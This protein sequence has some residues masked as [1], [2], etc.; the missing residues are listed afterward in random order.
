[1]SVVVQAFR[2]D[3]CTT[4]PRMIT[5]RPK[6]LTGVS[7]VGLATIRRHILHGVQKPIFDN[8]AVGKEAT[9]RIRQAARESQFDPG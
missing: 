7:Y 5:D 8:L 4:L 1:M 6:R 2:P 3:V 9:S